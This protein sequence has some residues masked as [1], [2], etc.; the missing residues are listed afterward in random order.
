MYYRGVQ[1]VV[2]VFDITNRQSFKSLEYWLQEFHQKQDLSTDLSL[3]S[4][5]L[6]GNKSD[7]G[8]PDL[9]RE[10]IESWIEE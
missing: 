7:L 9:Q 10:D 6:V 5:I 3:F 8:E 2:L 4:F 1:G